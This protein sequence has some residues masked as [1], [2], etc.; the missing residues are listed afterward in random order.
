VEKINDFIII[1]IKL[2]NMKPDS[3]CTGSRIKHI[4]QY[5]M[6]STSD[7]NNCCRL[8]PKPIKLIPISAVNLSDRGFFLILDYSEIEKVSFN[9][10]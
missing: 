9:M 10:K 3:K 1:I 4:V 6:Y 5:C 8:R 2:C 7:S